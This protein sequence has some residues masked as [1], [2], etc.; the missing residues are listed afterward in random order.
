MKS[1]GFS[2]ILFQVVPVLKMVTWTK[3][4]K[5]TE[6]RTQIWTFF[7]WLYIQDFRY[8][9]GID[10]VNHR[11]GLG[12]KKIKI[13]ESNC[14]PALPIPPLHHVPEHHTYTSFKYLQVWWLQNF[15]GLFWE[16]TWDNLLC[17]KNYSW[18]P[19]N[20]PFPS[21]VA[22]LFTLSSTPNNEKRQTVQFHCELNCVSFADLGSVHS[23]ALQVR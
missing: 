4:N 6:V 16:S 15:P 17:E 1:K 10:S 7:C 14:L 8:C 21:S 11:T 9:A 20:L 13:I 5:N 19:L 12:Q 3:N 23:K 2:W 22:L 18:C